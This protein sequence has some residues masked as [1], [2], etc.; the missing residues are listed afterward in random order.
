[1]RELDLKV[2]DF[3]SMSPGNGECSRFCVLKM[4]NNLKISAKKGVKSFV[5]RTNLEKHRLNLDDLLIVAKK[6]LEEIPQFPK[7]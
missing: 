5:Q 7:F 3:S 4:I 6:L 2:Q 1:M